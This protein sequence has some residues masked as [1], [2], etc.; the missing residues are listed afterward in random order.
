MCDDVAVNAAQRRLSASGVWSLSF[1]PGKMERP[2]RSGEVHRGAS[3]QRGLT[4]SFASTTDRLGELLLAPYPYV[5]LQPVGRSRSCH[6]RWLR[7]WPARARRAGWLAVLLTL[8][9]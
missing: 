8:L 6:A 3:H 2:D 1:E 7:W 5:G 4:S 9:L